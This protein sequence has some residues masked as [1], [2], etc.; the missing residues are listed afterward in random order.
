MQSNVTGPKFISIILFQVYFKN[1]KWG[2]QSKAE[3]ESDRQFQSIV[4][5]PMFFAI[6]QISEAYHLNCSILN[7]PDSCTLGDK[8]FLKTVHQ[9]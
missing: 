3:T 9:I 8:S 7:V 4:C 2:L 6:F 1:H 5:I